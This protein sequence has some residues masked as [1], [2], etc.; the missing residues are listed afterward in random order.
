MADALFYQEET[1]LS[2]RKRNQ[3]LYLPIILPL[4]V[5]L[6]LDDPVCLKGSSVP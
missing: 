5:T 1:V 4:P 3:S 2:R 6:D